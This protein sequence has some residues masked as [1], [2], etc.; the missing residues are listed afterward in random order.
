MVRAVVPSA[1]T[2]GWLRV[3]VM[4]KKRQMHSLA[5]KFGLMPN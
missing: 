1:S 5:L 2:K 3:A 4:L